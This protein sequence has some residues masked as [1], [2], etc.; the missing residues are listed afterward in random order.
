MERGGDEGLATLPL[1]VE[2]NSADNHCIGVNGDGGD[3]SKG[4]HWSSV[5]AVIVLSTAV[6]S[7]G[8]FNCGFIRGYSSPVENELMDDLGL[9]LAEYSVFVSIWAFG[10]I[11][12]SLT[13]GTA[14]DFI[15][16]RGTMLFAD[17]SCIIGWLLIALAKDHWLLDLGRFLT[18]FTAGHFTYVVPVYI[19]EI[20]PDNIRGGTTLT[21]SLMLCSG[22]S[23][24]FFIGTIVSWRTLAL[25]GMVPGLLQFIGLFFIP[26]SPRWLAKVGQDEELEVALQRLRGPSTNVSQE[27]ADIKDYTA[28][29]QQLSR[30]RILDLF[31]RRY[32]HSLIVGVGLIVLRQFSG[33]NAI[34]CYASSIF[35]SADFSSGFGT[36][37]IAIL[38]IPATALGLLIIDKFGR[39]PI[40]MVSAAGMCF[41]CFLAGLS[42]L[43]QDLKQWK[44]ITP[45]L[46]LISL[47]IYIAT[48][49]LGVSGVPWLVMSE[50]Y[51]IN[52]RGSAGG[53]VSLA[54]WSFS[55]V[56]TYTF[57]YMFEW[58]SPEDM[59]VLATLLQEHSSFTLSAATVLF[60]ARLIPETKGR[61]LEEIQASMTKFLE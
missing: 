10:G 46:V 27:A 43:R 40:L 5:T 26:E 19:S 9:S 16:R 41:S 33:N 60:T 2:E 52:I 8:S 20:T 17:I 22:S 7:F 51:P 11:I 48:F 57:N 35:E 34:W 23:L 30:S 38:Q 39:R 53:L 54:N 18:G 4:G 1:L 24:I 25:I 42:F 14:T 55:V 58:S 37:A 13:T 32:A 31:Q 45:I 3:G 29:F 28:T 61:T 12:A 36:R 59:N 49:S 21:N 56:V 44:D 15:G 6:A 50:I 47:L